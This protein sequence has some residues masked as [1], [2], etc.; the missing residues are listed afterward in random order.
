MSQKNPNQSKSEPGCLRPVD[1]VGVR[2]IRPYH[3]F[4][5]EVDIVLTAP[6]KVDIAGRQLI[7]VRRVETRPGNGSL[8]Q[9]SW[10]H[11][12]L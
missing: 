9:T 11:L 12:T 1:V 3:V 6:Q 2:Q 7:R 10:R 5:D 4:D 8:V